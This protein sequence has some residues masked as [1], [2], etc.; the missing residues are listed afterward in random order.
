MTVYRNLVDSAQAIVLA[1]R[2]IGI[3]CETLSN[4]VSPCC[5]LPYFLSMLGVDVLSCAFDYLLLFPLFYFNTPQPPL[6][7]FRA[8]G[9]A[10]L[11]RLPISA[12]PPSSPRCRLSTA[13]SPH[14][15]LSTHSLTHLALLD[16]LR[17]HN[18]LPHHHLRSWTTVASFI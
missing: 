8:S 6:L 15:H 13:S 10:C 9:A 3:D 17:S 4:R 11:D 2:K 16:E 7:P 12:L 1:M 5:F 18:Q 14:K